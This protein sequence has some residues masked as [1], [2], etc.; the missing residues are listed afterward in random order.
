MKSLNLTHCH[1]HEMSVVAIGR[2]YT[3]IRTNHDQ[4]IW[5]VYG[6]NLT[7]THVTTEDLI[8]MMNAESFTFF[9]IS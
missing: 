5:E 2:F 9:K 8:E 4:N 7:K 3:L 6:E 1:D